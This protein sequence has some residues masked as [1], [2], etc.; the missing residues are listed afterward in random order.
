VGAKVAGVAVLFSGPVGG[1]LT[2][3]GRT[4]ALKPGAKTGKYE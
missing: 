3:G 4:A 1:T 2:I